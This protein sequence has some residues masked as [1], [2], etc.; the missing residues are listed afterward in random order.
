MPIEDTERLQ[1]TL[2]ELKAAQTKLDQLDK[3]QGALMERLDKA[4]RSQ[5]H[6]TYFLAGLVVLCVLI[7]G[8]AFYVLVKS[9]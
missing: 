5:R 8:M 1:K 9:L 6:I 3:D 4:R 7:M 2:A